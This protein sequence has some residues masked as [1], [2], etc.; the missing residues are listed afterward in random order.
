M[1]TLLNK[2]AV[3]KYILDEVAA[4]RGH[5]KLTRVS[6][7]ALQRYENMLRLAIERDILTHPSVGKTFKPESRSDSKP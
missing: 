2:S 6:S 4:K 5:L 1:S 3:R 7:E